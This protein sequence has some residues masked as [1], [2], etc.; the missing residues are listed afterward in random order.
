MHM[1]HGDHIFL[2]LP[3]HLP[4]SSHY[5][6]CGDEDTAYKGYNTHA[7]IYIHTSTYMY[8]CIHY[9]YTYIHTYTNIYIHIYIYT[10]VHTYIYMYLRK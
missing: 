4:V 6:A 8:T 2:P 7:H 1:R 3:I 5:F 10:Y 9:V